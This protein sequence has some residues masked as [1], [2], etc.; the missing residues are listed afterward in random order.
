MNFDIK[1]GGFVR[2]LHTGIGHVVTVSTIG[3]LHS[4]VS[5]YDSL[6]SS[7]GTTLQSQIVCILSAKEAE[8]TLNFMDVPVQPGASD[9][10]VYA[11]AFAAAL[12]QG[13]QPECYVFTQHK[14]RAHL[15]R[16]L[17]GGRM[18]MFPYTEV[19]MRNACK[20]RAVHSSHLLLVQNA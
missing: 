11:I 4:T 7:A 1:A 17:I 12:A 15:R 19:C 14:M 20:I 10:G 18:K 9:C 13:K 6:Y 5:V 8:I 2:I 3:T 16:C